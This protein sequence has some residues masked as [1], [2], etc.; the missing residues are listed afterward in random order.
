[1]GP[2]WTT[3]RV[4]R[5]ILEIIFVF[6]EHLI[7]LETDISTRTLA[8]NSLQPSNQLQTCMQE[9]RQSNIDFVSS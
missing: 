1:M 7:Q 9:E 4:C 8:R 5:F 6:Q 2:M 3:E